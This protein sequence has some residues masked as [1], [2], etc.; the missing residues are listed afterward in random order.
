V[1]GELVTAAEL[2]DDVR[3]AI[4]FLLQPP[5][6][7]VRDTDGQ[8]I[9]AGGSAA[10]D[11]DTEDLDRDSGHSTSTDPSRYTGQTPGW[12]RVDGTL[13]FNGAV[14]AAGARGVSVRANGSTEYGFVDTYPT[15]STSSGISMSTAIF[16]DGVDDYVEL[17]AYNTD[18]ASRTLSGSIHGGSRMVVGYSSVT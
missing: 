16:L 15:S 8:T 12:Y 10:V 2:N 7:V 3:D 6:C 18:S 9:S 13:Q 11:F 14:G 1:T 4:N 5:L 17:V